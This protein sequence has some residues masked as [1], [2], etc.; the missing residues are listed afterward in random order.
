MDEVSPIEVHPAK[1]LSVLYSFL[2]KNEKLGLTG[3]ANKDIG[4]LATSRL[5]KIQDKTFAFTPQ[6]FDVSRNYMDCDTSLMMTTLEYGL[7]YLSTCWGTSGRPILTLILGDNMLGKIV[8]FQ[9]TNVSILIILDNGKIHPAMMS[10]LRKL[11]SGYINGTRVS[12]GTFEN[13]M[14]TAC[15]TNLSFL[16]S[17][18][19]GQP[20]K[21]LPEI[22]KFL[23]A[24]IGRSVTGVY[25]LLKSQA[26]PSGG[27]GSAAKRKLAMRGSI[28][29]SRSLK[30]SEVRK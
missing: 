18:E 3:R 17:V 27:A 6:R 12:L 30:L 24:Q 10:T 2:G 28:K 21:L 13:F 11:N 23:T 29:R 15:V 9:S 16:G 26:A 7:N 14:S 22:E 20:E 5:Y 4:I 25:E 8:K 19:R 1:I